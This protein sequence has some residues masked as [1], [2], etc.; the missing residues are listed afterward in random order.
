MKK[1]TLLAAMGLLL[2]GFYNKAYSQYYFY[3]NSSY[4][5][6]LMFEIGGSFGVMNSLT[7]LGGK[8]GLGKPFIKDLNLGKS[9]AN[10]S[11]YLTATY[12]DAVAIRLEGTFGNVEAYDSILKGVKASTNGRY[13]RNL[14]FR[15]KISEVS[16]VA[17]FHPL[18]I[19]INWASRD[20]EPTRISPYIAAGIGLFTFNPQAKNRDG[21]Y[22]DLQPLSTEGQGFA[23]YPERQPY[24]LTQMNF[25]LGIG[26]R[27]ELSPTF[28][29]RMELL[30]RVLRTDYLDDVSTRYPDYDKFALESGLTGNQLRDARDLYRNARNTGQIYSNEFRKTEGG[31]RGDPTDKDSYF[32]FNIKIGLVFGREKIR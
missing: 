5:T 14:A 10:G 32:T 15:S 25:P 24:K 6:P 19:F 4:D 11:I 22:V 7:D 3:D 30:H 13:E 12:K 31:I 23:S 28:N 2:T 26:V 9:R 17:E 8:K 1:I 18:F 16:L 29:L 27:Y 20:D 21:R